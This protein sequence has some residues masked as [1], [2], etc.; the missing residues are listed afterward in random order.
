M[1]IASA[2]GK[3]IAGSRIVPR[4]ISIFGKAPAEIPDSLAHPLAATTGPDGKATL[5]YLAVRDRLMTVR[6]TAEA[7]GTQDIVLISTIERRLRVERDHDQ[8]QAGHASRRAGLSTR[9]AGPSSVR[10][11]RSG[12]AGDDAW[13]RTQYRRVQERARCARRRRLVSN[14][15]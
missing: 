8:A 1:L 3:P 14:A 7:I 13:S 12:R 4:V 5:N 2:D 10:W 11:S 6:V 9:G 15:R